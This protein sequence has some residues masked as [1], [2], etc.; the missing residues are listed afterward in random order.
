M[1]W[2]VLALVFAGLAVK[3]LGSC[4]TTRQRTIWLVGL[5][6]SFPAAIVSAVQA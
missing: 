4:S 1:G 3:M 5:V 2:G 6:P